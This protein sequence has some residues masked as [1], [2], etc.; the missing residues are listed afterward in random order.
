VSSS[1]LHKRSL[2]TGSIPTTNQLLVGEVGIN[3]PDGKIYIQKSGSTG[4]SIESAITSNSTSSIGILTLSGSLILSGSPEI[5]SGSVLDVS[6]DNV[7][8]EFDY[9]SFSGSAE[10]TG[11]LD[12]TGTVSANT[13]TGSFVGDGSGLTNLNIDTGSF[14]TT[15]SFNNFTQSYY[16]DSA[17]FDT[18]INNI[19]VDTSSLV[20]TSSFNTFTSSYY[21]DSASFDTR[22]NNITFDTSSLVTTSSFNQF[23]S[24]YNSGSFSGSFVGDGSGLSGVGSSLDYSPAA[25]IWFLG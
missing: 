13:F 23:T 14:T 24:S 6:T 17:S 16:T 3:V 1:I 21:N 10:I 11:S 15:S 12:V 19:T 4:Q 25:R 7:E 8:F 18:R 20:T 22:I 9:L 5:N 2:I